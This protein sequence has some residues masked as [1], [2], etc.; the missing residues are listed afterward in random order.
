MISRIAADTALS[1]RENAPVISGKRRDSSPD[2]HPVSRQGP[3]ARGHK[4]GLPL[5]A[6]KPLLLRPKHGFVHIPALLLK[7]SVL[8]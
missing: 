7:Q 2:P 3:A 4:Q 1:R 6:A 5:Q 8:S